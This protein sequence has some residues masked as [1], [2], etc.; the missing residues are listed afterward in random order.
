M[1]QL[2]PSYRKLGHVIGQDVPIAHGKLPWLPESSC[3][4]LPYLGLVAV[5]LNRWQDT[6]VNWQIQDVAQRLASTKLYPCH[7]GSTS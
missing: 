4:M 2:C 5:S 7:N 1:R 6:F 3:Q